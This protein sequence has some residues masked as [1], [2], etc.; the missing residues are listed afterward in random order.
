MD[1]ISV[2][3]FW[4]I[5]LFVHFALAVALLGGITL[6]TVAVLMPVRQAAGTFIQRLRPGPAAS[7]AAAIVIR[8]LTG[9]PDRLSPA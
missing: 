3:T 5:L 6:Q 8:H 1:I 9:G 2:Q 4:K 7:Y